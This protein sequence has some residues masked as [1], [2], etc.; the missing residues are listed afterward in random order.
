MQSEAS[1]QAGGQ[2]LPFCEA[3]PH[4]VKEWTLVRCNRA[5]T[6]SRSLNREGAGSVAMCPRGQVTSDLRLYLPGAE[7]KENTEE[8]GLTVA[9]QQG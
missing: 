3:L 6:R 5:P 7:V 1:L 8:G 9:C 2:A 4:A